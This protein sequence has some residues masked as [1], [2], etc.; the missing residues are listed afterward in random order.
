[1]PGP[2]RRALLPQERAGRMVRGPVSPQ[3]VFAPMP[4]GLRARLSGLGDCPGVNR[5]SVSRL[6]LLGPSLHLTGKWEKG[7]VGRGLL[8]TGRKGPVVVLRK[9]DGTLS[10]PW[11]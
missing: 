3:S 7:S 4:R 8:R 2:A 5:V 6:A 10:R 9:G 1:M 11:V